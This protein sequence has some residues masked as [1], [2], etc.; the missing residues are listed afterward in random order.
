M[1]FSRISSRTRP[2]S[3]WPRISF[4]TAPMRAPAAATLPSRILSATS[5]L[6]AMA[7]ST[8][9]D[10][11]PSSE[12]ISR[13]AGGDDLLGGALAGEQAVEH[14][15][16]ELVVDPAAVDQGLYGGDLLGRHAERVDLDARVVGA[17]G[18]L[19]QPPLARRLGGGP[20]GDRLLDQRERSG[21]DRVAHLEVGESPVG[22]QAGPLRR[23][24]LRQRAAQLLDPL[25]R[26]GDGHQVR[27]REVAV[28]LGVGLLATRRRDAGVLVPVAGLLQDPLPRVEDRGVPRHLVADGALDRAQRV[29]VLGLGP[30]AQHV[31]P[32]GRQRQVDVGADRALLHPGVRDAERDDQVAELSDVRAGDVRRLRPRTG[33]RLGDDLDE[34]D[35]GPVVV[36]QRVV[37]TVDPAGRAT[38]VEGLAGVLLHVGALDLDSERLSIYVD[39]HVALEADRLVVLRRLEVLGHVRVEVVLPREPAPLR[40]FAVQRQPDPDR[41]LDRLAVDDRHRA[42]QAQAGRADLGVRVGAEL[43]RAAAEH[44]GHGVELDVDLEAQRRVVRRQHVVE[45][46]QRLGH[47]APPW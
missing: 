25:P 9:V 10:R 6:A 19:G 17:P 47:R 20:G 2:A 33:D 18:Q 8:A 28:V 29:D 22:L 27:L 37:R 46:H 7:L 14:L 12:T 1:S 5:G 23:G 42:G 13:P 15:A 30:G 21:A 26:R 24:V 39:V 40:N 4:I 45:G 41:R 34:R 38:D 3:A 43:R 36:D 44:L 32:L 16:G 35:P 11:A 31:G